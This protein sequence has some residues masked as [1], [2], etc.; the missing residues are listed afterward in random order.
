MPAT[1]SN[2]NPQPLPAHIALKIYKTSILI[3]KDR[4]RYVT[5]EHRF[6]N[7]YGKGNPRK[8][9]RSACLSCSLFLTVACA[10]Y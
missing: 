7:G 8:M 4:D 2:P 1:A 3:F 6:R 5:G 10:R 9:V